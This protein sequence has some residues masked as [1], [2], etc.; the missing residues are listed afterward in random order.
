MVLHVPQSYSNII[1]RIEPPND[2]LR[3]ERRFEVVYCDKGIGQSAISRVQQLRKSELLLKLRQMEEKIQNTSCCQGESK[4][5]IEEDLIELDKLKSNVKYN[6]AGVSYAMYVE[7]LQKVQN[8]FEVE[9]EPPKREKHLQKYRDVIVNYPEVNAELTNDAILGT[10][11]T[12][13]QSFDSHCSDITE[14]G[15]IPIYSQYPEQIY[16][17]NS[18]HPLTLHDKVDILYTVKGI[19]TQPPKLPLREERQTHGIELVYYVD[20]ICE[21]AIPKGKKSKKKTDNETLKE[22]KNEINTTYSKRAK[23]L[24]KKR[25][26]MKKSMKENDIKVPTFALKPELPPIQVTSENLVLDMIHRK[27]KH[28]NSPGSHEMDLGY[29]T[30]HTSNKVGERRNNN[31][32]QEYLDDEGVENCIQD[33][34]KANNLN[35]DTN[36]KRDTIESQREINR[37]TQNTFIINKSV[38]QTYDSLIDLN[39]SDSTNELYKRAES[40]ETKP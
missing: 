29:K 10:E 6:A 21:L 34:I 14:E 25:N 37:S 16:K 5:G 1:G 4:V 39:Q 38:K 19:K 15:R 27:K 28:S 17:N 26:L 24:L 30:V 32:D 22:M 40:M 12:I 7:E 35:C 13:N 33:G 11:I 2:P 20:G 18:V 9:C 8:N 23:V 36:D 3:E 31:D